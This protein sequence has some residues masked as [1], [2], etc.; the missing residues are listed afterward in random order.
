[1]LQLLPDT[2]SFINS[3][4]RSP[5]FFPLPKPLRRF[6]CFR[7]CSHPSLDTA[8]CK[9]SILSPSL[10]IFA[11]VKCQLATRTHTAE[12]GPLHVNKQLTARNSMGF[13]CNIS[14]RRSGAEGLL[15]EALWRVEYEV[16]PLDER[17]VHCFRQPICLLRSV[18][19]W[20]TSR[21]CLAL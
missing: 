6:S 4:F 12:N 15:W 20:S 11:R 10:E 5:S 7:C 3:L 17:A 18:V 2:S 13:L 9:R 21:R 14:G 1:M 8:K 19:C 16:I